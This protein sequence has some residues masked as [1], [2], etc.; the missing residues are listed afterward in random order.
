M[1]AL[2]TDVFDNYFSTRIKLGGTTKMAG[3]PDQVAL[4]REIPRKIEEHLAQRR[5]AFHY[6]IQGSIGK[7]NIARVPWV[8]IF[9]KDITVNAENGY[10]IVLL[11]SEDMSRCYLSLN[12]GI[13]AV[14]ERYTKKFA[15]KKMAEVADQ[16]WKFLDPEPELWKG[17]I[18]LKATKDLGKAYQCAAIASREYFRTSLPSDQTFFTHLDELLEHYDRLYERLGK[19][20]HSLLSIHESEFQQVVLEKAAQRSDAKFDDDLQKDSFTHFGTSSMGPLRSPAVSAAAI[21]TA[22]FLCE[23]DQNHQTFMSRAKG[24]RYVEAHHLIPISKQQ[25]FHVS[26]DVVANIVSL[27]ANCHRQLHYGIDKDRKSLL[28]S[29]FNRRRKRLQERAIDVSADDFLGFY[30]AGL[31]IDD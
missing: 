26:L 27:C 23:I 17:P 20:L 22:N 30:A 2:L 31:A 21:R 29:L 12:Q 11:F 16:A 4:L 24:Q 5:K 9:R 3:Y 14:E 25:L 19:S 18:D 28:K 7:G 13:T 10:Y 15:W 6:K 8:S 1:Q